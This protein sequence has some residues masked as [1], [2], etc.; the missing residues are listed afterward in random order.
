M[1]KK[2]LK[3]L[4][5][6][7][8]RIGKIWGLETPRMLVFY[9]T[10]SF[11]ESSSNIDWGVWAVVKSDIRKKFNLHG[12]LQLRHNEKINPLECLPGIAAIL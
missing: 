7:K 5:F 10:A 6:F 4:V 11:V 9:Q 12:N 3:E 8:S 1:L 2:C